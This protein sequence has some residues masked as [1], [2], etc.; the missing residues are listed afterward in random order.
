[1]NVPLP[2]VLE[3]DASTMLG[4]SVGLG[5]LIVSQVEPPLTEY[6]NCAQPE[7]PPLSR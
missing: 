1:M 5:M 2:D 7:G 3:P 6:C 4:E